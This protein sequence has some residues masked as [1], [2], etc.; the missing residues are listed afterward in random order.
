VSVCGGMDAHIPLC[1][2]QTSSS[3]IRFYRSEF[4]L[5][6]CSPSG[7]LWRL[8]RVSVPPQHIC[9]YILPRSAAYLYV[10]IYADPPVARPMNETLFFQQIKASSDLVVGAL[11]VLF[12][13]SIP[14]PFSLYYC[15]CPI[16]RGVW[17][18]CHG[19][20]ACRGLSATLCLCLCAPSLSIV[21]A[22]WLTRT[23]S[24]SISDRTPF[25]PV[26][27]PFCP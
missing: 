15:H 2:W 5:G 8:S 10:D 24:H 18:R 13:L 25:H 11:V 7:S 16:V 12:S 9:N 17:C 21:S 1:P 23:L 19:M 14:T 4:L 22:H 6:V 20:N 3:C 27:S 26:P